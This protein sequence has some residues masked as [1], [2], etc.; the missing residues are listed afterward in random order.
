MAVTALVLSVIA[1][2]VAGVTA[3][4]TRRQATAADRQAVAA[5]E[6]RRIEA[7]R[8]HD[9]LQP[10]LVGEYVAA[11][12]TREGQRPGVKLTNEGPLD[13]LRVDV[14]VIPAHRAHEAAIEGLYDHRT[15]GTAPVHETGTLPRGESWTFEVIPT[16]KVIDGQKLDRGGTVRFRCICHADGYKPWDVVVPVDFPS[17]PFVGFI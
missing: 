2:V 3:L 5:E 6:A 12:D 14:G 4:Y 7:D 16:Q 8:R 9:E 15:G 1:I 10:S 13:L 11:S 17:T